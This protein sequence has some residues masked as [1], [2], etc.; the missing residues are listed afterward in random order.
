MKRFKQIDWMLQVALILFAIA[1]SFS[2][3]DGYPFLTGYFIVGGW[4]FAS[5][6]V[7][8]FAG[9]FT[10]KGGRRRVYHTAVYIL[11]ALMLAGIAVPMFLV[12]FLF[13]FF[14]APVMA[15]WYAHLCYDETRHHMQRPLAQLK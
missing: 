2:G 5:I 4:Q 9:S 8:E 10:A 13:M 14:A 7:H 6:L 15:V 12:T 11:T 1:Y 3:N